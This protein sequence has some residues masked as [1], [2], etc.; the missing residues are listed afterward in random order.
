MQ[1][2]ELR[3][4]TGIKLMEHQSNFNHKCLYDFSRSPSLTSSA[5][6]MVMTMPLIQQP[7]P[8][9]RKISPL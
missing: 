9:Y 1:K 6:A 2:G 8:Y 4:Q 5:T 3:K 7:S